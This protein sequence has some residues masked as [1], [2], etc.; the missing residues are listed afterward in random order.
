[1]IALTERREVNQVIQKKEIEMNLSSSCMSSLR[2]WLAGH[3]HTNHPT[4]MDMFYKFVDQYVVD[5]GCSVDEQGLR[6][7]I[8]TLVKSDYPV[9]PTALIS[10]KI[11]LMYK[12]MDFIRV[13]GR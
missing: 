9:E 11:G 7:L 4:D 3:W 6:H 10:E 8:A 12:I 5:H 13:T 1:M 2:R